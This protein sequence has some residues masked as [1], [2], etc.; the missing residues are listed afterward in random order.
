MEDP[1][2]A[3]FLRAE[4]MRMENNFEEAIPLY[5]QILKLDPHDLG[6][7]NNLA[8]L[9][10]VFGDREKGIRSYYQLAQEYREL[11]EMD[12]VESFLRK[13]K[14]LDVA[15]TIDV[16]AQANKELEEIEGPGPAVDV[17]DEASR[18]PRDRAD[19]FEDEG[20]AEVELKAPIFGALPPDEIK[21]VLKAI[22][23][24]KA[25]KGTVLFREGDLTHS[26]FI[27]GDGAVQIRAQ[28]SESAPADP[29]SVAM[30]GPG[31]FFGEFSFLTG[32]PR[33]AMAT[34]MSDVDATLYVLSRQAMDDISREDSVLLAELERYYRVRALDLLFARSPLFAGLPMED[35]RK[36]ATRFEL[37]SYPPG[38]TLIEEGKMGDEFFLIKSGE[39][40]I[41]RRGP[42]GSP[43][44]MALLGPNQFFG[45]ISVLM[46]KPRS[47]SVV[48]TTEAQILSVSGQALHDI[49]AAYPSVKAQLERSR[50][51]RAVEIA[52]KLSGRPLD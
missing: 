26:L 47:A 29:S 45:E 43:I 44:L 36:I 5:E 10:L 41:V 12:K 4:T 33:S 31:E 24:V 11:G 17:P 40:Q 28:G 23:V 2:L 18:K 8:E 48:T 30:L 9:Y 51:R 52:K 13:I 20:R 46:G 35:R 3:L 19:L 22:R 39:V 34:V 27:I 37:R 7:R 14:I 6:A 49:I 15:C 21:K 50:L 25:P 38:S 16:T 1:K 32:A 42:T